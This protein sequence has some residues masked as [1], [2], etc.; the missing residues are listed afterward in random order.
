MAE[1]AGRVVGVVALTGLFNNTVECFEFV[2]LGRAFGKDFQTSQLKLNNA[3]HRL[4]RWGKS[5]SL[6]EDVRDTASLQG[7]FGS[8]ANVKHGEALLGQIIARSGM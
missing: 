5:L 3:R 7:R 1:T 2:Q 6:D 8:E 4:S